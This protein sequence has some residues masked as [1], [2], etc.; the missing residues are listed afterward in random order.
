MYYTIDQVLC[1]RDPQTLYNTTTTTNNKS[2]TEN[3]DASEDDNG[4]ITI[5]HDLR[6]FNREKNARLEISKRLFQGVI[7]KFPIQVK[8]I[9]IC[10]APFVF[11]AFFRLVSLF[12]P[13]K[14]RGRIHFIANFEQLDQ[15]HMNVLDPKTDLLPEMGGTFEWNVNE[16]IK[17]QKIK[18][19][20]ETIPYKSLTNINPIVPA[21]SSSMPSS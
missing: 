15:D 17:E 20:S 10:Y 1:Q 13:K 14:L 7:G 5:I 12:M 2:T 16:W 18:E 21:A 8:A 9:Y 6:G 11:V 3:D 19:Q 4:G